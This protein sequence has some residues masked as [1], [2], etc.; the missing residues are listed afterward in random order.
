MQVAAKRAKQRIQKTSSWFK[1]RAL[2]TSAAVKAAAAKIGLGK[3]K[4]KKVAKL[5]KKAEKK[6]TKPLWGGWKGKKAK[7]SWG[8]Q[9]KVA[10]AL[11]K[12]GI[13]ASAT[14]RMMKV[15]PM[16]HH[17][18]CS[19]THHTLKPCTAPSCTQDKAAKKKSWA[20]NSALDACLDR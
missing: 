14:K 8:A 20:L 17:T 2:Q 18:A 7:V 9:K 6:L 19:T 3:K 10:K 13:G 5:V 4:A 11:K 1:G 12:V 15:W 16:Q